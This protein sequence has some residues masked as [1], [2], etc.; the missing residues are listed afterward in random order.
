MKNTRI[1][2]VLLTMA[3]IAC[4]WS[5]V[6]DPSDK[7]TQAELDR[8]AETEGLRFMHGYDWISWVDYCKGRGA[9]DDMFVAA[10]SKVAER[11]MGAEYWTDDEYKCMKAI[12]SIR[13][14]NVA[15]SNLTTVV[16]LVKNAKSPRVRSAAAST[17][18]KHTKGTDDYLDFAE[19]ILLSTNL[20]SEVEAMVISGLWHDSRA[21]QSERGVW[22]K[23]VSKLMRDYVGRDVRDL[24]GA[25]QILKWTDPSYESSPLRRS[26]RNRILAPEFKDVIDRHKGG[27]GAGERVQSKY[28]R[29][30][31]EERGLAK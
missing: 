11:T 25:D 21:K 26:I 20:Q 5:A 31:E 6:A 7:L 23:R 18:Y 2:L 15:A 27:I 1:G 10:F 24:D 4:L 12:S 8:L 16:Q 19:D 28:R 17:Y 13:E 14:F 3:S 30:E 29:E 22:G 9:T